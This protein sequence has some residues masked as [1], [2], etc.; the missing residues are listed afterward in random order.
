MRSS[1]RLG[2][3]QVCEIV[4][5]IPQDHGSAWLGGP[6]EHS[7]RRVLDG[8]NAFFRDGFTLV[9]FVCKPGA[10]LTL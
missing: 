7:F 6:S 3:A 1:M 2:D 4:M 8:L 10:Q 5:K 9:I